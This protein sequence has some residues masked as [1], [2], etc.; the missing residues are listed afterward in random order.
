MYSHLGS[1]PRCYNRWLQF[2]SALVILEDV[3]SS[4]LIWEPIMFNRKLNSYPVFIQVIMTYT[5]FH[6]SFI[7]FIFYFYFWENGS[8][9]DN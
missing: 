3:Y 6:S 5:K 9:L 7:L 1:L 8:H 2:F 4:F